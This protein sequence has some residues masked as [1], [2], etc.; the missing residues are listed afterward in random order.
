MKLPLR[1]Q[2]TPKLGDERR[3]Q[4]I[5]FG[6]TWTKRKG[7]LVAER[8]LRARPPRP[9]STRSWVRKAGVDVT[10]GKRLCASESWES[11]DEDERM[12][13]RVLDLWLEH[14]MTQ[15]ENPAFV[16]E[17]VAP[18]TV[19]FVQRLLVALR[20]PKRGEKYA[21]RMIELLVEMGE[22]SDTM[23][24][25]KP[26]RSPEVIA[27]REKFSSE[28]PV[29]SEGGREA[30]PSQ[31]HSYWWRLFRIT[32]VKDLIWQMRWELGIATWNDPPLPAL[33]SLSARLFRQGHDLDQ[34]RT[35]SFA[36]GS[37]QWAFANSGPP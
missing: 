26:K 37:A 30:Q 13:M 5:P 33:A 11:K 17:D 4:K 12:G 22:I 35:R 16:D 19:A 15:T 28:D 8:E 36:K 21:A 6:V 9:R 31:E 24:V 34:K 2:G 1:V 27:R 3:L 14:R 23:K 20:S 29:A 7:L 18:L 32:R 10:R 25:M